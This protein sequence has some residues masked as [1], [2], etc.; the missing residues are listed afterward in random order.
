MNMGQRGQALLE[1]VMIMGV[2][3]VVWL[4]VAKSLTDHGVFQKVFGNTWT[5]LSST[6]E[7]GIPASGAD[8]NKYRAAH[9]SGRNRHATRLSEVN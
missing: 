9:P 4:A 3:I 8:I 1:T 6:I 5:R 2:I 7:L